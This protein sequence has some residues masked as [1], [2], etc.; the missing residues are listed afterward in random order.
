LAQLLV[1]GKRRIHT[2]RCSK[3]HAGEG[4]R[5]VVVVRGEE[6]EREREQRRSSIRGLFFFGPAEM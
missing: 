2:V 4:D 3:R 1:P 6:R 5:E